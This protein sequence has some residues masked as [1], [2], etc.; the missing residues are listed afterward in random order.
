MEEINKVPENE[1]VLYMIDIYYIFTFCFWRNILGTGDSYVYYSWDIK[2]MSNICLKKLGEFQKIRRFYFPSHHLAIVSKFKKTPLKVSSFSN[3]INIKKYILWIFNFIF[4]KKNSPDFHKPCLGSNRCSF[5]FS[6]FSTKVVDSATGRT[7]WHTSGG[8]H[9]DG[10]RN[11]GRGEPNI[12]ATRPDFK[13]A[14]WS[15]TRHEFLVTKTRNPWKAGW[16]S[17]HF[18]FPNLGNRTRPESDFCYPSPSLR[19]AR[20]GGK[21]GLSFQIALVL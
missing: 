17:R 21:P 12:L 18:C 14:T 3:K 5:Q 6:D 11:P 10:Y 7:R 20:D 8:R 1:L 2:K 9:S 13:N 19:T 16:K 15:P 4:I